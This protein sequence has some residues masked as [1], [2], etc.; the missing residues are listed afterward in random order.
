MVTTL[1]ITHFT[2][3]LSLYWKLIPKIKPVYPKKTRLEAPE[4][5]RDNPEAV[6]GF[7]MNKVPFKKRTTSAIRRH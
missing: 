7:F 3:H 6:Y 4:P 5:L 2:H 1:S